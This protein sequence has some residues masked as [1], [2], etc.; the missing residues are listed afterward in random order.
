MNR[1]Y[2]PVRKV[3]DRDALLRPAREPQFR[4]PHPE[5][6]P[7]SLVNS[8]YFLVPFGLICVGMLIARALGYVR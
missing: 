2:F 7:A 6:Q 5:R 4:Y 1:A 8:W 3:R